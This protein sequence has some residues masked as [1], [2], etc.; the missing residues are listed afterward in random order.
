[1]LGK[2]KT[3]KPA[4]SRSFVSLM[5]GE[6]PTI[7]AAGEGE[8][9]SLPKFRMVAYTGVAVQQFAW[10]APIV[11]DLAGM[12]IPNRPIPIRNSH[13]RVGGIGHATARVEGGK[14]LAE[15][16]VSRDTAEAHEVVASLRN[17]FP[18]QASVGASVQSEEYVK[19]GTTVSVNGNQFV[20]PL[21]VVRKSKLYEI[22]FVDAGADSNTEAR[23]AA[24]LA[25]VG[26][27]A[28][29]MDRDDIQATGEKPV[30]T[31]KSDTANVG[32]APKLDTEAQIRAHRDAL[33]IEAERVSAINRVASGNPEIQAKAIRE[34]WTAEKAELEV[35][36]ASRPAIHAGSPATDVPESRIIE[37]AV[38]QAARHPGVEKLY[39]DKEL[40]AA[41]MRYRGGIGLGEM[42]FEAARANGYTGRNTK[43]VKALLEHAFPRN[44]QAGFSTVDIPGILS[45]TANKFL[46]DG[47]FFVES[48]W[49]E[50]AGIRSANDFKTMT[51]YRLTGNDTYQ[52][53]APTGEIKHGDLEETS[54]TNKVDTY[55]LMLSI[56]RQDIINDDLSALTTVPRKLGAGAGKKIN[57][58]FWTEFKDNASFF[59]TGRGNYIEGATTAL[60][61]NGLTA[62]EAAFMD[63]L[64][65]D[66][67]PTG[68]M[69]RILLVPTALSA[70]ASQLMNSMEVRDTTASTN[71]GT[72]NPHQG[73]FR[74]VVSRYLNDSDLAYYLLADPLDVPTIEIAFLNGN[75]SPTVETADADFNM[76]GI[77]M[78]GYHDFGVSLADYLGGLK[79]KGEA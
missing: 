27:E 5:P 19:A 21:Y 57:D 31:G 12:T 79:V 18:W 47:F 63:M 45:N 26:V 51:V 42:L 25:A 10:D 3:N 16:V 49:R 74:P 48:A 38:M 65:T 60:G 76:L 11:I 14:L 52:Q 73:K 35:I 68:V 29:D 36:R 58:V 54:Y 53:V 61:I 66:G 32:D 50:I 7:E 15:G 20:G 33:A 6:V 75:Q 62:A 78:R 17:G 67:N 40:S 22:S 9:Q 13:S 69:P 70:R 37:A 71:Y 41:S 44:I 28:T 8:G 39:T 4:E 55:G 2:K 43:D 24:A 1:M 30:T 72:S 46:Q 59:T 34:G 77:K 56:T 64:D 23:I